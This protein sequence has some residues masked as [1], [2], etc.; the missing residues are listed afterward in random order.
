MTVAAGPAPAPVRISQP[1]EIR[2]EFERE[3]EA[4]LHEERTLRARAEQA[5]HQLIA[6]L[7]G[8]EEAR[9]AQEQSDAE[10]ARGVRRAQLVS[11]HV[12]TSLDIRTDHLMRGFTLDSDGN[13]I[14]YR[15]TGG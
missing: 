5:S 14:H 7:R 10:L 9:A 13:L 15:D 2:Q 12:W 3:L 8:E 6:S 4:A 1:G 11:D